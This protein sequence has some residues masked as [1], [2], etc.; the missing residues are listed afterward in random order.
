M[1]V[2]GS[3]LSDVGQG[4]DGAVGGGGGIVGAAVVVV[5]VVVGGTVAA[6]VE[7]VGAGVMRGTVSS[8]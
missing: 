2:G 6:T 7:T 8:P 1:F 3:V 5:E 4:V